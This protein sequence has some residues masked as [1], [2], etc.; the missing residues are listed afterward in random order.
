[1]IFGKEKGKFRLTDWDGGV[2]YLAASA[3][4]EKSG[5]GLTGYLAG[6]E[7]EVSR[8]HQNSLFF[9]KWIATFTDCKVFC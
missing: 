3:G 9:F 6:E 8:I 7:A 4:K 1:V 2:D 5:Q